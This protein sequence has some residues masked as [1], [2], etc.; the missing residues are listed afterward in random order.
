MFPR[1]PGRKSGDSGS[2]GSSRI[3][4]ARWVVFKPGV[5]RLPPGAFMEG[6]SWLS[7]HHASNRDNTG[8]KKRFLTFANRVPE[9]PEASGG[10]PASPAECPSAVPP[11]TANLFFWR[12]TS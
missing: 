2:L 12:L 6:R 4:M 3:C 5:P 1:S 9:L 7:P 8:G 10:I 11:V